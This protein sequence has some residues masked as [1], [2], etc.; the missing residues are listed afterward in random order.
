MVHYALFMLHYTLPDRA[1]GT[2][3]LKKWYICNRTPL[4]REDK[5]TR[6]EADF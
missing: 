1:V 4:K 2:F 5:Y 6:S 3:D